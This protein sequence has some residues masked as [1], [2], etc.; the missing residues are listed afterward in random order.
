MEKSELGR[1]NRGNALHQIKRK[2]EKETQPDSLKS[3][4]NLRD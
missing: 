2:E 3:G 1:K 4:Q